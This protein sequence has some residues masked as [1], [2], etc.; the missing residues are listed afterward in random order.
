VVGRAAQLNGRQ[1]LLAAAV[2]GSL[3]LVMIALKDLILIQLH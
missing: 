1:L 2:E 3:G